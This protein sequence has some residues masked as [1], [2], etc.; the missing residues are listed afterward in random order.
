MVATSAKSLGRESDSHVPMSKETVNTYPLTLLNHR[1]KPLKTK[2]AFP[3]RLIKDFGL[4]GVEVFGAP[5]KFSS[6]D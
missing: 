2:T 3:D 1:G 6:K 4:G 5:T